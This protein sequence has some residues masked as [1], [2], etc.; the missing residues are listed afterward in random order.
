MSHHPTTNLILLIIAIAAL[1]LKSGVAQNLSPVVQ[2]KNDASDPVTDADFYLQKSVA[3]IAELQTFVNS[4]RSKSSLRQLPYRPV[5]LSKRDVKQAFYTLDLA[6]VEIDQLPDHIRAGQL[7]QY[8]QLKRQAEQ[9]KQYLTV[10]RTGIQAVLDPK[11]FPDL[12]ADAVRFREI[13]TM[14]ANIDSFKTDPDLAATIFRQLPIAQKEAD[15]IVAKYDLLIQQRTIAGIQLTGLNRYFASKRKSFEAI[16]KQQLLIL[17]PQIKDSLEQAAKKLRQPG[18]GTGASGQ[19]TDL[20]VQLQKTTADLKLLKAIDP[21]TSDFSLSQRKKLVDLQSR[22]QETKPSDN[23]AGDDRDELLTAFSPLAA[24]LDL[25]SVHV[26]AKN[27]TRR[28]YWQYND[29]QWLKIDQ[30]VLA[31]YVLPNK[32]VSKEASSNWLQYW[33]TKDHLSDDAISIGPNDHH[34]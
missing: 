26:P 10:A 18:Q 14:L 31:V 5:M 9:L 13:G 8:Q 23:Y 2:A 11:G 29:G 30:S 16:A 21:Q 22:L 33:L 24:K 34:K 6:K 32:N 1:P 15:R 7:R 25:S 3:K 28:S 20:R 12:K 4:L 19:L 27:W 17:P